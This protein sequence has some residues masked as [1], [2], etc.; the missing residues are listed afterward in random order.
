MPTPRFRPLA[1]ALSA[2][3]CAAAPVALAQEVLFDQSQLVT[4]PSLPCLPAGTHPSQLQAGNLLLGVPAQLA[5]NTRVADDFTVPAS[6]TDGW[7]VTG[8]TFFAWM[9]SSPPQ[10]PSP[11][12]AAYV[13]VWSG[14]PGSVGATLI[15]GDLV[16][17]RMVSS[18]F[19]GLYRVGTSCSTSRPI[20]TV[21]VSL[22]QGFT[23][24]PEQTY[25]VEWT[26]TGSA[27]FS[28]PF[29]PPATVTGQRSILFAN[30]RWFNG[31]TWTPIFDANPPNSDP[32]YPP[33]EQAMPFIVRGTA[34]GSVPSCYANCDQSTVAP[35]LNVLDFNCFLNQFSSGAS[36]ANCDQSTANPVLNVLDFNC[37]LNRF[38][39]GCSAP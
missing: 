20:Y 5:A 10:S 11:I 22:D 8:L 15:Y 29:V 36:Y 23:A 27:S 12:T 7:V 18:T 35:V 19:A 26:L 24:L 21:E 34:P 17:N 14:V 3:I 39:A 9:S 25:W 30:A 6:A 13:R 33:V 31:T 2:G 38:S 37:F 1:F 28:G 16:T 4:T 32:N